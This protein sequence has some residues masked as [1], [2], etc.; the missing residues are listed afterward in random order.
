MD[1]SRW[2]LVEAYFRH[3]SLTQQTLDSFDDFVT[4]VAP[5]VIARYPSVTARGKRRD[6]AHTFTFD[7]F[8]VREPSVVEK[9]GDVC[10]CVPDDA[11]VR[12]YTY[13]APFYARLRHKGPEGR[14]TLECYL[15][16]LP[17]M[18]R[19]SRCNTRVLGA[20]RECPQDPGGYFI[21]N[22][23]EKTLIPQERV[24]ENTILCWQDHGVP[25]AV[26]HA[27][28]DP[29]RH[30]YVPLQMV[31][32]DA[33]GAVHV[34]LTDDKRKYPVAAFLRHLGSTRE[35]DHEN[36]SLWAAAPDETF[37]A[38]KVYPHC[39]TV[40]EK[41]ATAELQLQTLLDCM[42]GDREYDSRDAMRNKRLDTAGSLLGVL[43]S[44][45]WSK[46]MG[47][48]R[49]KTTKLIDMNRAV[50]VQR[51]T[52]TP[53]LT[54][55]FKYALATGN[56]RV[57]GTSS[58]GKVGVSQAVNRNTFVSCI[59]Q[60]R[61][62][63]SS[64]SSDQKL[65]EPRLLRGDVW[66]FVCPSETPE[67]APVG[68]V[69]QLA[70]SARI[71]SHTDAD[72]FRAFLKEHAAEEGTPVFWNGAYVQRVADAPACLERGRQMRAA[73]ILSPDVSLSLTRDGLFVW[74]DSGRI[75][76]PVIPRTADL[77]P[78]LLSDVRSGHTTWDQLYTLGAVENL[79]PYETLNAVVALGPAEL[80]PRA[81][82]MEL[83][84]SLILGTVPSTI[85]FPDHNQAPRNTYQSAMGKQAMGVYAT[86]FLERYDTTGYCLHYPQ[87]ALVAPR[88][89]ETIGVDALPSGI[90]AVVA[91]LCFGG[92]NQEDSVLVNRR[93]I[94]L[95]GADATV[96]RTYTGYAQGAS[97]YALGKPDADK[98]RYA[99]DY[100]IIDDDGLP[101]RGST[102]TKGMVLIGRT[103]A[104]GNDASVV[105]HKNEAIIDDVIMF[106][107]QEG[108]RTVK[109]KVRERCVPEM[110]DK[111]SSRH[112]QKGTIGMIYSPEDFPFTADGITPDII[113]NPHA[114]PSRMTVGHIFE[115]LCGIF[116][117]ATGQKRVDATPFAHE[118]VE[119]IVEKLKA[120]QGD[121][122]GNTLL[123]HPFTGKPLR[124][125]VFM[126]PTYY[127]RLKHMVRDKMHARPRGKVV[128][129]T[130][131]PNHGR[132][133]GGGLRFGE[134]ERD[135]GIAHGAPNVLRERM[136]LSSDA[137]EA[138][139]C[140]C[141]TIGCT[142]RETRT[143]TMPYPSKLL[144]QELMS[145][146]VEVKIQ[147][148]V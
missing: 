44:S 115:C 7:R 126:G 18:V 28:A 56:W 108:G 140:A 4:R 100:S 91:I 63:D 43:F 136:L 75:Y 120:Y 35:F 96:Y 137:Y 98:R 124:G 105:Y 11:R 3:V 64:V 142:C 117:C 139:V 55:G 86:S 110:G 31:W 125:E 53:D 87:R 123:Y 94:D 146:G 22:G 1:D 52:E 72:E 19:S 6:E 134:M 81:T 143:V 132:A 109:V 111:F 70:L 37:V 128:G 51:L 12:S 29:Y 42:R 66:G 130:R 49:N 45:M 38:S 129:L 106:D 88:A 73:R 77:T 34:V 48:L 41:R 26:V 85:P 54:S 103:D 32:S 33:A 24:A 104:D 119:Q 40:A 90:N 141:G 21:I 89:C 30:T 65:V 20:A 118:S 145:M 95:G 107:N 76:R 59:S 131:Q 74:A 25:T 83:H 67:G 8:E 84:P 122:T 133:S 58:R 78:A 46:F 57:K 92:F 138:P 135:C 71:S 93:F 9:D 116:A 114:I 10:A 82:H 15:G 127:Q 36:W 60:L 113:I 68:L 121:G 112:G 147:T 79:D 50:N 97:G 62:F 80:G 17:V 148:T 102:V 39:A 61:R 99:R 144:C 14:Q 16:R 13:S 69:S 101:A 5:A 47:D 27:C 2:T 23:Q